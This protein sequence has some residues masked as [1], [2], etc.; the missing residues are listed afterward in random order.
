MSRTIANSPGGCAA[1]SRPVFPIVPDGVC[2]LFFPVLVRD[3]HDAAERL[4]ARGVDALEFWN[5]SCEPGG[6][7]M[8]SDAQFLRRHVLELPIHQ[9]LTPRHIDHIARQMAEPRARGGRVM[10]ATYQR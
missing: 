8:G 4:R 10:G 2:P 7:E 3:K 5:D 1:R 6:H 9:D